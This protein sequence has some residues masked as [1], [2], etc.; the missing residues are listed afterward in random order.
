LRGLS[1][2]V[3]TVR[4]DS[5][6]L[7]KEAK[8]EVV[9]RE[10]RGIV[11][12]DVVEVI[13]EK[14]AQEPGETEESAA[15]AAPLIAVE[16]KKV[17]QEAIE[18]LRLLGKKVRRRTKRERDRLWCRLD[19]AV[20]QL[21]GM[22]ARTSNE[23]SVWRLRDR[24]PGVYKSVDPRTLPPKSRAEFFKAYPEERRKLKG[25]PLSKGHLITVRRVNGRTKIRVKP[26]P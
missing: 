11:G 20:K 7:Y 17:S 6:R 22:T 16:G 18:R 3:A 19:L 15:E 8:D 2:F 13:A 12:V 25:R 23:P 26:L 14:V 4:Y 9:A 5:F 10:R 1:R 24:P 21:L